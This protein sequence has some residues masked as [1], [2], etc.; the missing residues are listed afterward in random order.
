VLL[1]QRIN[2]NAM[3]MKRVLKLG[4]LLFTVTVPLPYFKVAHTI[5]FK[6]IPKRIF[7]KGQVC[8]ALQHKIVHDSD[9]CVSLE[10]SDHPVLQNGDRVVVANIMPHLGQPRGALLV[11]AIIKVIELLERVSGHPFADKAFVKHPVR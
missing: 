6:L 5:R 11:Q 1:V 10:V 9:L 2:V 8:D 3:L 7:C 4:Q